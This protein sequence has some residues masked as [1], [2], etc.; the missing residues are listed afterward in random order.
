MNLERAI[1]IAVQ[2]HKGSVDKGGRPYVLHPLAV[3]HALE[4]DA[5]KIVGVLHDVVEDS[6]WTFERLVDEGFSEEIIEALR[7]V[8]KSPEDT[9]YFAFIRRVKKNPISRRVKIADIEHNMDMKR[10]SAV[11]ED[12]LLRQRKY[13]RALALIRNESVDL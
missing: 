11:S 8:T 4:S 10:I 1:E 7:S 9:D 12:D 5:E 13:K 2:A 6:E 3:M